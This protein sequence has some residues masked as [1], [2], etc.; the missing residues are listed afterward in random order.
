[1]YCLQNMDYRQKTYFVIFQNN[2]IDIVEKYSNGKNNK[3]E[4][5]FYIFLF[6]PPNVFILYPKI[7]LKTGP[8]S[9]VIKN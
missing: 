5:P 1:M 7:W 3:Y 9:R 8:V 4:Y 2:V 6:Y